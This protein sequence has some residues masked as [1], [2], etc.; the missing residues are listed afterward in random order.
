VKG[1]GQDRDGE[2]YIMATEDLGPVG[3]TGTVLKI[4][5]PNAP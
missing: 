5:Q 4:T 2:V 1:F 3:T